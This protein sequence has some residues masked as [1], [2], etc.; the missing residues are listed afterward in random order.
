M[1]RKR[2]KKPGP[3]GG[4]GVRYGVRARRRYTEILSNLRK[5]HACPKCSS[6]SV[7]RK[8]VGVWF[9][10]KCDLQFAG[11][12]YMPST[13]LGITSARTSRNT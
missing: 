9:C 1:A 10:I 13:K 2:K 6:Y 8:S 5:K 4:L 3:T 7:K 12:A 11:G